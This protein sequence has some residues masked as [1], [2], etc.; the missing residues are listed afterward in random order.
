MIDVEIVLKEID[1]LIN[2]LTRI[3]K[4]SQDNLKMQAKK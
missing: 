2:V 4:T 1:S 3:V